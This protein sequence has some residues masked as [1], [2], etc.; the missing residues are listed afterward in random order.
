M[1]FA[2]GF[3]KGFGLIQKTINDDRDAKIRE[4][5]LADNAAY[6]NEQLDL[7]RERNRMTEDANEAAQKYRDD[8][9]A[10][11]KRQFGIREARGASEFEAGQEARDASARTGELNAQTANLNAS[12]RASAEGRQAAQDRLLRDGQL[13]TQLN[14]IAQLPIEQQSQYD[15]F[16]SQAFK[17]LKGS[18]ALDLDVMMRSDFKE[19]GAELAGAMQK[20]GAGDDVELTS[21][22]LAAVTDTL[23]IKNSA[24][25]GKEID[26]SFTNASTEMQAGGYTVEDITVADIKQDGSTFGADL[27]V[28]VRGPDGTISYY[29]PP[30]TEFRGGA[31]SP[32]SLEFDQTMQAIAGR[33]YMM[34]EMKNNVLFTQQ[35]EK[36]RIRE[37]GGEDKLTAEVRTETD[38][39][40]GL[41]KDANT[42]ANSA[43]SN[44]TNGVI[45]VGESIPEIKANRQLV[46]DRVRSQLLYGKS[47][48]SEVSD[49]ETFLDNVRSAL[50]EATIVMPTESSATAT[51]STRANSGPGGRN[52]V[53][54]REVPVSSIVDINSLD[55]QTL[56]RLYHL[57]DEG[58]FAGEDVPTVLQL[59][60][61]NG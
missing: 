17:D 21:S 8:S 28:K 56:A 31:S 5:Q 51:K 1:S 6:R 42:E 41:I 11:Q 50:Q 20:I 29:Y 30:L 14:E 54:S 33:S 32:L 10:E 36:Q 18:K 3:Q 37:F 23:D 9:L 7:S 25:I 35:V 38:R 24:L 19:Y 15:D 60:K 2:D 22:M 47:T 58:R 13:I 40:Y 49:S 16:V 43:L 55:R 27:A 39:I 53:S 46:K 59:F 45:S 12:T 44:E 57:G 61:Y 52:S 34:N 4:K 26:A 48:A